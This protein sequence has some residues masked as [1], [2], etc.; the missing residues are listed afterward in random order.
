[1]PVTPPESAKAFWPVFF[2]CHCWV[3]SGSGRLLILNLKQ[4][5][6]T[7]VT[8]PAP[9][10]PEPLETVQVWLGFVGWV[11][12]LTLRPVTVPPIA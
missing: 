10:V 9:T 6:L 4:V 1:M 3:A 11:R 8:L 7:F 5:T 2:K 12:T